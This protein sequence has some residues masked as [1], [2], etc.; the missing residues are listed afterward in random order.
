MSTPRKRHDR[1]EVLVAAEAICDR[2][3]WTH[4]TMTALA[5]EL[6]VKVPSLYNHVPNLEALRGELQNLSLI[7]I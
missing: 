1:E 5:N 7:H 6:G 4:L 3:G 2:D